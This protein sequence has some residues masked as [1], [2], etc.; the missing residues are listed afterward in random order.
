MPGGTA[1]A[2]SIRIPC[3][4]HKG[5]VGCNDSVS[6]S[7][8]NARGVAFVRDQDDAPCRSSAHGP[9][10]SGL[11]AEEEIWLRARPSR[12]GRVAAPMLFTDVHAVPPGVAVRPTGP[13]HADPG[14]GHADRLAR[15]PLREARALRADTENLSQV[16]SRASPRSLLAP[17]QGRCGPP[18]LRREDDPRLAARNRS[19][20]CR[21]LDRFLAEWRSKLQSSGCGD[22]ALE[23]LT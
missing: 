2:S 19:V 7:N 10:F 15:A 18:P 8:R 23:L 16:D 20:R 12:S 9:G 21:V 17:P 4:S 1:S 14:P 11:L 6:I 22:G 3:H 13:R 5:I